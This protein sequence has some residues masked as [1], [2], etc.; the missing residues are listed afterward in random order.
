[1]PD[2][3]APSHDAVTT[4]LNATATCPQC[5]VVLDPLT[6][7]CGACGAVITSGAEDG[8]RG[9]RVRLRLQDAIG[10]TFTLGDL[11]GRGGMGI[12]FRA[13][14]KA[15]DR[16]VALKVLAFDPVLNPEAYERFEREARLAA[17]LDHP[18]I[19]PIFAVGQRNGVAYYTMRLVKGGNVEQRVIPGQGFELPYAV[20]VLRDVA[21]ALDYAH[22][23]G[24]VHRDIKPA[25]ILIGDSGHA[26]VADFGIARAF[27]GDANASVATRTGVVGS[28]AYMSPEQ[29][30]GEKVEG[31][32]DQY[33]LG[34]LAFELLTGRR[35]FA[36]AS[37]QELLRM[38]LTED[39]PDVVSFRDDLPGHLTG[40]IWRAM[41]KDPADRFPTATD[42]VDALAGEAAA[43]Q[44]HEW[45]GAGRRSS[46]RSSV[47]Q[48]TRTLS[49]SSAPT[50]RPTP[51]PGMIEAAAP[52]HASS[53]GFWLIAVLLLLV[54]GLGGMLWVG[55]RQPAQPVA[56]TTVPVTTAAS[57]DS[58]AAFERAQNEESD[59]QKAEIAE[60]RRIALEA[61]SRV[62]QLQAAQRRSG[63][64][65]VAP[66]IEMHGHLF[67]MA[68]GGTPAVFVDGAKVAAAS[69]AVIEVKP[70]HH[71]IT[72][73]GGAAEFEPAE[74]NLDVAARDTMNVTFMS[75]QMA[76]RLR[77][78]L[79]GRVSPVPDAAAAA[80]N[81]DGASGSPLVGISVAAPAVQSPA[82]AAV[83][84]G[85]TTAP[86]PVNAEQRSRTQPPRRPF[87]GLLLRK[88]PG[89]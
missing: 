22:T 26:M 11:L 80:G 19:V 52:V 57:A 85:G 68:R 43:V 38:H 77:Q 89:L 33:A 62:E 40:A 31:K 13:R 59:R 41:S 24:V 1:M 76:Q 50:L 30:R 44:P 78:R 28:P 9:E 2:N 7:S 67:V 70:G 16:D 54:G 79:N 34:I 4:P 69:P 53:R 63:G 36:D 12:V 81:T 15:L 47:P 17:K 55:A 6:L 66:L 46:S 21:S 83:A 25:N 84:D 60:L 86:T 8:G 18:N 87:T 71:V 61:E 64:R 29:W 58:F 20:A 88:R 39:P 48:L 65:S 27:G 5:G 72:V 10:D 14:E 45:T 73:Q 42:F 75:K 56:A 32:A 35:P 23:N 82:G 74:Y 37:M 49:R 3:P 51:R